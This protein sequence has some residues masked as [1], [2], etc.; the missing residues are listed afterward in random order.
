MYSTSS[1]TISSS[2]TRSTKDPRAAESSEVAVV[3]SQ[4]GRRPLDLCA[5]LG[6][7]E[8]AILLYDCEP[9]AAED[10]LSVLVAQ[11]RAL[12]I[13]NA[14]APL[15]KLTISAGGVI[16]DGSHSLSLLYR[17]ADE[18]LYTVKRGGRNGA[19]LGPLVDS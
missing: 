12:G 8:F 18:Q 7:E 13:D 17:S 11:V 4:F 3:L 14:D 9:A 16:S 15:R 19:Q 5:R 2:Q 10:R 6:G 1:G